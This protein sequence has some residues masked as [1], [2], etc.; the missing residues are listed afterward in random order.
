MRSAGVVVNAQD[1]AA[2]SGGGARPQP[3]QFNIRGDNWKEVIAAAEK[4]KA[5][6]KQQPG[7]VDV[8]ITYR[9]GKPQLSV[10]IDRRARRQRRR[11]RGA[12]LARRCAPSWAATP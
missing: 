10:E 4:V 1:Y 12:C 3:V 7:F 8:D 9:S 5:A 6:M 11:A 2:V